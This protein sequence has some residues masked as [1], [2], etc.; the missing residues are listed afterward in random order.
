MLGPRG[1]TS[2]TTDSGAETW[3]TLRASSQRGVVDLMLYGEIGA[4]GISANQFARDLKALGD[5]SQI[6]LH[7]H[8]PGGDVFEGMAMYNLLRNHPARVEGTV[9]GLAASMGSVILMAANV[10][11]IPENAMIMVHKPWGIQGGDADEMRR[12]ADLLDKVEDSLVAAYSTRPARPLTRS[13]R[14]SLRKRG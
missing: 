2:K 5:V 10:I 9:D 7:V 11:R 12:Y 1:S 8:S 4:W 6:N 14:C 3:Y 13:R